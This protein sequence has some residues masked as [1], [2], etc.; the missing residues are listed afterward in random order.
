MAKKQ[1]F[2][3]KNY[4]LH[5]VVESQLRRAALSVC[6][7]LSEGSAKKGLRDRI[8]FFNIAY[9]SQKEVQMIIE[10][11]ELHQ[12][13]DIANQMAAQIYRLQQNAPK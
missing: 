4:K 9:A 8:R 12:A 3:L 11:E 7:N 1:Y 6:L 5:F 2:I 13:K 10:L